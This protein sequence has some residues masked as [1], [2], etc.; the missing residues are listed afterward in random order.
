[1]ILFTFTVTVTIL[2]ILEKKKDHAKLKKLYAKISGLI[3]RNA[4]DGAW[5]VRAFDNY[6]KVI[7]SKKCREGKIYLNSQSWA[8]LSGVH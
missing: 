7:G 2:L 8:I 3:N 6:G 1:L 5:Y 4:W